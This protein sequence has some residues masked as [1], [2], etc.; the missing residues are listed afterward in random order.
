LII[1][2]SLLDD[3]YETFVLTLINGKQSLSCNEVS[4]ALVNY[5]LRKN[6]KESS[7]STSTEALT[8]REVSFNH[9]KGKGNF[10]KSKTDGREDLKKNQ[11]A[12]CKEEE[13]LKI[14]CSKLKTKESKSEINVA[15]AN[16]NDFDS[17][18]F[19]LSP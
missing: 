15:M 9:R 19:S 13:H 3:E 5:E 10:E 4:V 16:S 6:N 14:D 11:C 12:F 17:S 1:L 8:A 7:I 2:S 18:I